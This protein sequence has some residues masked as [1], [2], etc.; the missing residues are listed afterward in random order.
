MLNDILHKN[1][2]NYEYIYGIFLI[3]FRIVPKI[4]SG[5]KDKFC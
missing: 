2:Y 4:I 5:I 3:E 1:R